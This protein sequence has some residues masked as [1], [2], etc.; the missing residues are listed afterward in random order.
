MVIKTNRYLIVLLLLFFMSLFVSLLFVFYSLLFSYSNFFSFSLQ[1]KF[2]FYSSLIEVDHME[3]HSWHNKSDNHYTFDMEFHY[4]HV[5]CREQFSSR[6]NCL[7]SWILAYILKNQKQLLLQIDNILIQYSGV[8][9]VLKVFVLMQ[10]IS[11][12]GVLLLKSSFSL[13]H[14]L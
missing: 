3:Y 5:N 11:I 7:K 1:I 2:L 14:S 4:P 9:L 6:N 13:Y 10:L 12:G 8:N